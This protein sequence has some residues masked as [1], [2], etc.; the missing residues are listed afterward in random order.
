[1]FKKEIEEKLARV[2]VLDRMYQ[3]IHQERYETLLAVAEL[4]CPHDKGDL[5]VT[6]KGIGM[7]GLEVSQIISPPYARQG[8]LW[9]VVCTAFSKTGE[10]TKRTVT[11]AEQEVERYG[12]TKK[13]AP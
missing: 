3:E 5:L 2:Q 1:M 8:N 10:L 13:E 9:A 6:N 7:A 11:I 4:A 12:L